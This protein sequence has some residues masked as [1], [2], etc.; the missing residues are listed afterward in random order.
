MYS[1]K[2]FQSSQ[3]LCFGVKKKKKKKNYYYPKISHSY[4]H[5]AIMKVA[6]I[7]LPWYSNYVCYKVIHV[8]IFK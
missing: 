8:Q 2:Q 6:G 5:G 1:S 3:K 7:L 4:P